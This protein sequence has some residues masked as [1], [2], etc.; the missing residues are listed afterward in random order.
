MRV[1]LVQNCAI[2]GLGYIAE[3]LQDQRFES[4]TVHPYRNDAFPDPSAFDAVIVGGSP[5]SAC[6]IEGHSSLSSEWDFL[7]RWIT[8]ERPLIGICFGA[9]VL[10]RLLGAEVRRNPVREIGGYEVRLTD[11]GRSDPLLDG[12]PPTFQVFHWHGDTFDVPEGAALLVEGHDCRNQL[13][14]RNLAVG[15]Q[16]HL[17]VPSMEAAVWAEDYADELASVGKSRAE[18]IE[19]CRSEEVGMRELLYRMLD[20]F[21]KLV[22][23]RSPAT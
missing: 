21:F 16:F 18:V 17:E 8:E 15:V 20:N 11:E 23:D 13:Y 3:Y 1:L 7:Q 5:T 22:K 14:R 9:Q 2:E 10:A 12:F 6:E 4:V 19:Q